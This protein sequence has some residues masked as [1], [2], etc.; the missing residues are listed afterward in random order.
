MRDKRLIACRTW[1]WLPIPSHQSHLPINLFTDKP[2]REGTGKQDVE[3]ETIKAGAII[4]QLKHWIG[5][6]CM[7]LAEDRRQAFS[8]QQKMKQKQIGKRWSCAPYFKEK[9]VISCHTLSRLGRGRGADE[10]RQVWTFKDTTVSQE[11]SIKFQSLTIGT[12]QK[13]S[14]AERVK[15]YNSNM[16]LIKVPMR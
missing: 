10:E 7:L 5:I 8:L 15:A 12:N 3:W 1:G 6:S 11:I 4:G 2:I 16:L 14:Y 13:K 9:Y